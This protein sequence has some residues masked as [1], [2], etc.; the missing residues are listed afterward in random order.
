[1]EAGRNGYVRVEGA[2][3]L[4]RA[5]KKAELD[6]ER[7]ALKEA[8]REAAEIVAKRAT[9]VVPEVSGTL[10]GSIRASGTQ[11][12]GIVRA[13]RKSV[14]YAGVI[15]FGWPRRNISPQPY[16]YEAADDRVNEVL[17]TYLERVDQILDNI[18]K[19]AMFL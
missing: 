1:M 9:Q 16:L 2:K 10:K 3:E 6:V 19:E 5:L 4:R 15:H 12:K 11:T 8:H 7:A 14:P 17:E 18:A 13:G